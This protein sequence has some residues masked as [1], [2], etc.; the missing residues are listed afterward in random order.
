MKKLMFIAIA[1]ITLSTLAQDKRR[2]DSNEFHKQKAFH[3]DL[4]PEEIATLKTKKMTLHLDLTDDQQ[5]KVKVLALNEA[6]IRKEK[7]EAHEKKSNTET[8]QDLSKDEYYKLLNEKLDRQI[9]IK[10]QMKVILD[11]EQY[12]KWEKS[13]SEKKFRK[14]KRGSKEKSKKEH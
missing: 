2:E 14:R 10:K 5:S 1:L 7:M 9:E 8:A 4:T 13:L 12:E 3:K 11:D 6:K